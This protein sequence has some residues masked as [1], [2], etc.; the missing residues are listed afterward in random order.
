[1]ASAPVL[2][3]LMTTRRFIPTR[4]WEDARQLRGL[5]GEHAAIAFLTSCGWSVEAHRFKLGRHD[6]D[7]VVR[8]GAVVAFVEVKTRRSTTFGLA[9]EAV[10]WRK[11]RTLSRVAELWR[12][13]H[14]RPGDTYR[15]DLVSVTDA[16]NGRMDVEHLGDAWRLERR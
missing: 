16:G 3:S 1:M 7:L 6:L 13:R 4:E 14:G 10:G 5:A 15:F 12:L 11:Q 9:A 8:R 2:A